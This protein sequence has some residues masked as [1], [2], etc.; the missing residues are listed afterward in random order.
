MRSCC[1]RGS[2]LAKPRLGVPDL[3]IEFP[4]ML[5]GAGFYGKRVS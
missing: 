2:E 4:E 1:C 5:E 3:G